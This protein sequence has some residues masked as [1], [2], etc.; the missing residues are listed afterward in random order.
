MHLTLNTS[1]TSFLLYFLVTYVFIKFNPVSSTK[2][3]LPGLSPEIIKTAERIVTKSDEKQDVCT[4]CRN[5]VR[6]FERVSLVI[7]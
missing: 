2:S 5:L 3:Q 1:A 6:S 7:E 4:V